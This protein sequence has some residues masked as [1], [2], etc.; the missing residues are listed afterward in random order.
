[1]P[2]ARRK[3]TR[4]DADRIEDSLSVIAKA[5]DDA[6][7]YIASHPWKK[8]KS[9]DIQKAFDFH[10]KLVNNIDSWAQSYMEKSGIMDIYNSIQNNKQ[11]ERK[12]QFSGGIGDVLKSG[13]I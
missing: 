2:Q 1:M 13:K 8:E 12:G 7:D 3:P 5:I 10:T 6:K 9:E 4:V 11:K